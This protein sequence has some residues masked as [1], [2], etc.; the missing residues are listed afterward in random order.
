M[1]N[2]A[3]HYTSFPR[4]HRPK[5]TNPSK[6]T[7]V[8]W[9]NNNKICELRG[10]TKPIEPGMC[11][12]TGKAK[13]SCCLTHHKMHK[14][15]TRAKKGSPQRVNKKTQYHKSWTQG[16]HGSNRFQPPQ[17]GRRWNKNLWPYIMP[18][19]ETRSPPWLTPT[20]GKNMQW[21]II[22]YFPKQGFL[23]KGQCHWQ[24]APWTT[25]AP[26]R[27]DDNEFLKKENEKFRNLVVLVYIDK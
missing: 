19:M 14:A 2:K 4:S 11:P 10:C 21:K 25:T 17:T 15:S 1:K 12:S 3:S 8:Y 23:P 18:S 27:H 7:T 13:K 24:H 9:K 16:K 5:E 20:T 26:L 22:N 6:P